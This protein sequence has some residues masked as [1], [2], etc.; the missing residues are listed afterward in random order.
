[1]ITSRLNISAEGR[2]EAAPLW[3]MFHALDGKL[4]FEAMPKPYVPHTDPIVVQ[5]WSFADSI[6][7][8]VTIRSISGSWSVFGLYGCDDEVLPRVRQYIE[9]TVQKIQIRR[10]EKEGR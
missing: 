3:E 9:D 4:L 10:A 5:G 8:I 2:R 1:M 6:P 7:V